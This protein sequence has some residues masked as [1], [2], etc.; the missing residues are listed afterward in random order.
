MLWPLSHCPPLPMITLNNWLTIPFKPSHSPYTALSCPMKIPLLSH[1][2]YACLCPLTHLCP[3][4]KTKVPFVQMMSLSRH[5][6]RNIFAIWSH[7]AAE[8]FPFSFFFTTS[9]SFHWK[10]SSSKLSDL[11]YHPTAKSLYELSESEGALVLTPIVI[12]LIRK[13][14]SE[15][16]TIRHWEMLNYFVLV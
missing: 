14:L 2:C 13:Q 15:R 16:L 12:C 4:P 6:V 1:L 8:Y 9:I 7:Y 11:L 3:T 10:A 5:N